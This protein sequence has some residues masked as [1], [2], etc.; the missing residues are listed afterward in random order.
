MLLTIIASSYLPLFLLLMATMAFMYASV[1]HG[2][3]SGYLA[4]L[5]LFAVE[6]SLMKSSA[7]ILNIFV[8]LISF[9]NYYKGGYFKWKLFL[10]F[11]LASIPA[12]YLGASIPLSADIYKKILGLCLVF[13]VL[14][15]AGLFGKENEETREL[16]WSYGLIIG[17][18]IGFLSGMIGIGGGIILSPV[19]LLFHW[20]KMK[21]TAAVSALFI[22]VNSISGLIALTAKGFV[23]NPEIYPWLIA[24]VLGGFAG[25]YLGS[26]K[27]NTNVLR[28]ILAAVLLVASIKLM[29]T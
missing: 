19:I 13:P 18:L 2:G 29:L 22:L 25:A 11:A 10:P 4:I 14:R 24:A 1:G 6:P 7:L 8:S 27:F 17:A 15:L 26:K 28:Y 16:K 21:E 23:P 12:A 3:A 9:A 5:A 20:A